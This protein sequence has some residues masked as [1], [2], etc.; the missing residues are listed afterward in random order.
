MHFTFV[1]IICLVK[2]GHPGA[3]FYASTM[4]R[5][6]EMACFK[7]SVDDTLKK[8]KLSPPLLHYVNAYFCR[9]DRDSVKLIK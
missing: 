8:Y 4:H 5:E 3:A 7:G 2:C 6:G 9:M 1:G